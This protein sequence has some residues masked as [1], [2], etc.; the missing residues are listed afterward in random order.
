MPLASQHKHVLVVEDDEL[1]AEYYRE[2]L[3]M[4]GWDVM[5]VGTGTSALDVLQ[6]RPVDVLLLDIYLPDYNG[7]EILKIINDEGLPVAVVTI[8]NQGSIELAIEAMQLGAHDFLQKPVEIDRLQT[9]INNAY[10][11]LKLC[12]T[13]QFYEQ[14]F[15]RDKFHNLVGASLPMQSVFRIIESGAS[16]KATVFITGESGT[17]KELCAEAIHQ[18]SSRADGPFVA[19]NCAAIPKDLMESEIFGHVKGAFT[20]AVKDRE[21]AASQANGGTLFMDEICEMSLDIQSKFLRFFQSR[22]FQ[23]VGSNKDETV[24]IR[25]VCA[26][27]KDPLE[28][29]QKGF[30]R[31]DLFYRLHVIP[32]AMPPLRERGDDILLIARKFLFDFAREES[33]RFTK[34]TPEVE[35]ILLNYSWQGNVRELQNVIRNIVV[36]HDAEV[37]VRKMLPTPLDKVEVSANN[38]ESIR[39]ASSN[40]VDI[41][42]VVGNRGE[43]RKIVPLWQVEMEAIEDA[44]GQCDGNILKAAEL[45]DIN[46]STI[47]R[48]RKKWESL[49]G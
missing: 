41:T 13:V 39:L 23:K 9:T 34:F 4:D 46:P 12:H 1:L 11:H 40:I 21:G 18:Q 42:G 24:D 49:S 32:I 7:L 25:F 37:V 14:S 43:Q 8:T 36:L 3:Q 2:I 48:K 30:F 5:A 15:Q 20:G 19:L 35:D 27:N 10:K 16:S 6:H 38:V 26:T 17:G 33:K 31:E 44:I 47:Y 29:V 22:H 28:M 45:L